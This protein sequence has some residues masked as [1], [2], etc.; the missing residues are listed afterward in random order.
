MCLLFV[1]SFFVGAKK[2]NNRKKAK[3]KQRHMT[4][5]SVVGFTT[6]R[7]RTAGNNSN[8]NSIFLC[9]AIF[10]VLC[11]YVAFFALHSLR[12]RVFYATRIFL[13][14]NSFFVVFSNKKWNKK[15]ERTQL[16]PSPRVLVTLERKKLFFH[17][18][19]LFLTH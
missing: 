13:S 18:N 19:Y 17:F 14:L 16:K 10:Y 6:T 8:I 2:Y 9:S 5:M 15:N 3:Q 1:V 4:C 11:F 7:K 12:S